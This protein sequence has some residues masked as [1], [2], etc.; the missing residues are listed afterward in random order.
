[1]PT[2]EYHPVSAKAVASFLDKI[3]L[4]EKLEGMSRQE[5]MNALLA[6]IPPDAVR[7]AERQIALTMATIKGG[8]GRHRRGK[9]EN[10]RGHGRKV[11]H[12]GF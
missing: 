11:G 10:K 8:G 9:Q 6:A 5:K 12:L 7:K 3:V 1:M 2:D 4:P